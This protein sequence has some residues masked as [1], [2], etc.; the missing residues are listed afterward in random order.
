MN[1]IGI[2]ALVSA[3]RGDAGFD[4][5]RAL[6]DGGADANLKFA[7][8]NAAKW[9]Q[10]TPA[11]H[12]DVLAALCVAAVAKQRAA[13]CA[14]FGAAGAASAR[15]PSVSFVRADGDTAIARRVAAFA[16]DWEA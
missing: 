11:A 1:R 13:L 15:S 8:A 14:L 4:V 16:L 7:G 3:V 10:L 9:A 5:V 2:P 6:L 12:R